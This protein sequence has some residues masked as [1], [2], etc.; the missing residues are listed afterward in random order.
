LTV[1]YWINLGIDD[2]SNYPFKTTIIQKGLNIAESRFDGDFKIKI[3][4]EDFK[5]KVFWSLY[6]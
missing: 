5:D 2:K 3:P 6:G 4:I 1:K